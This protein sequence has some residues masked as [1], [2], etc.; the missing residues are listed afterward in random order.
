[1]SVLIICLLQLSL[2]FLWLLCLLIYWENTSSPAVI[3]LEHLGLISFSFSPAVTFQ[4]IGAFVQKE[5][6]SYTHTCITFFT[7]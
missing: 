3:Y 6:D 2:T 4:P 5:S 7:L 1:M